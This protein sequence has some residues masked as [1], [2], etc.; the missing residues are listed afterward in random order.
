MITPREIIRDYVTLLDLLYQNPDKSYDGIM[1]T[2]SPE[3][4]RKT[5][6]AKRNHFTENEDKN[7]EKNNGMTQGQNRPKITIDDIQF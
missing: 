6:N 7:V 4:E 1:A 3:A 5:D 2:N